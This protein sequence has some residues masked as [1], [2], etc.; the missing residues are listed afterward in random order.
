M[1]VSLY[2]M[3]KYRDFD[4][5]GRGECFC[6]VV[7]SCVLVGRILEVFRAGLLGVHSLF[8]D[9]AKLLWRHCQDFHFGILLAK[10]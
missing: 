7:G 6:L 2:R 9:K 1:W 8:V 3:C 10:L 5:W 4:F